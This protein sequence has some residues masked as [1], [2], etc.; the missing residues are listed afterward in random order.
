ML[1]NIRHYI[2]L[3]K[4]SKNYKYDLDAI[5]AQAIPEAPLHQR[6][7]WLVDLLHWVRYTGAFRE[8]K[9]V[10]NVKVPAARLKFLFMVLD[11][12]LHWK[13]N[14]A[15]TLRSILRD[16]R[17]VDL[18]SEAGLSE[19]QSFLGEVYKRIS[20]KIMPDRPLSEGLSPLFAA[21]FPYSTDVEWVASLDPQMLLRIMD[22]VSYEET[23]TENWRHQMQ[24]DIEEA[25][26][27]L[28][29]QVRAMGMSSAIRKR[30]DVKSIRE[31]PFFEFTKEVESLISN[32][33]N[34]EQDA[35]ADQVKNVRKLIWKCMDSFN[36]VYRHLDKYGV[37]TTVV[38]ILESAQGKLKRIDD[39]V[40]L[41]GVESVDPEMLLYFVSQLIEENQDR[42]SLKSLLQQNLRLISR[43]I[44]DRSAETGAHYIT[45]NKAEYVGL[46]KKA[47]GGG[48][49]TAFTVL[50]KL[51]TSALG[52][53][54]FI[55][56]FLF[57][58]NYAFSFVA[59][60]LA[61]F[62]LATKQ[63]AMTGPAIASKLQHLD[64]GDSVEILVDEIVKLIRSQ[65]VGILGNVLAV[66]P[67]SLV[68]SFIYYAI[69]GYHIVSSPEKAAYI[70]Q[71][72]NILGPTIIFA[73]F[74]GIL[75]WL[76]SI[77]AGYIDNWFFLN[78][79]KDVITYNLRLNFVFGA[80]RCK[81]FASYM[82]KNIS[83]FAA[84]VS[85]GILLGLV[86]QIMSFLG[87]FLDVRHVTLSSGTFALASVYY[88]WSVF[89]MQE[90]WLALV[91]IGFIGSLNVGVSFS[92]AFFVAIRSRNIKSIQ[93]KA[94]YISILSRLKKEPLSF[95][96]PRESLKGP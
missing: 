79:M 1:D 89:Q 65:I 68:I 69:T 81:S 67:V 3:W 59:I 27:I 95:I 45:Q 66:I 9:E 78:R 17:A 35:F 70:F 47:C 52:L 19:E 18:F 83:G 75:L 41:M 34:S 23:S 88:G 36:E 29:A 7:V 5:L 48:A 15:K 25:L 82:E 8:Y 85:L 37:N 12:N 44:V 72:T 51:M 94:I 61:G 63:P 96:F 62:T 14:A 32:Y 86:P 38:F 74:T 84:N 22:F 10:E 60:Q 2:Q 53:P 30:M 73:S 4:L 13:L 26:F 71:S 80:A 21:L 16:V 40:T 55:E 90:F 91:G 87:T 56:G 20:L 76:S 31:L 58:V 42:Q 49:V 43:K 54:L 24:Q 11:R 93:R 92:L 46:F 6:L 33:R 39:L 28:A 64:A 77:F 50:I 57:S